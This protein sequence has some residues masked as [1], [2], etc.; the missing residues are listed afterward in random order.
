MEIVGVLIVEIRRT[1]K[2]KRFDPTGLV[3]RFDRC[4]GS[5]KKFARE[6]EQPRRCNG[7]A[8]PPV[9]SIMGDVIDRVL[10]LYAARFGRK[11]CGLLPKQIAHE[12]FD[13]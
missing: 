11:G 12:F 7:H 8:T 10:L 13:S 9:D 6:R 4:S 2:R 5:D 1:W 3:L